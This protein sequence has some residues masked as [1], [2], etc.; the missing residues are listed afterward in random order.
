MQTFTYLHKEISYRKEGSGFPVVLLH[1]FA[2]DS[3]VWKYQSVFLQSHCTL[4]IP[5]LP[6][7]GSSA[8][9]ETE[10]DNDITIADYAACIYALLQ[11]ENI[12]SCIVLGHSMG[13]YITLALAENYPNL[14]E[15]FG[16]VQST[17]FADSEEKK[18]MRVK[19]IHTIEQYGSYA[20]VKGTTP[21]LF[22]DDYKAT[23]ASEIESLIQKGNGFGKAALQQ[24]YKAMMLRED[25]TLVLQNSA[26]PVLF[27]LGTEDKAVPLADGL[28]QAHLPNI[29]YIHILQKVGHMAMW[30][31]ADEVNEC[32]LKFIQD[33][34]H[35]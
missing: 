26:V 13:G 23:H 20:F 19:G 5:D 10:G 16:F 14:V 22:T 35:A 24:Y 4:I 32:L 29:A 27:I 25:K 1:G 3:S 34:F 9:L 30:E 15:G 28:R 2:E 18:A 6:G 11:K 21:G 8:L 12:E 17:A 31:E 7:S 33:I